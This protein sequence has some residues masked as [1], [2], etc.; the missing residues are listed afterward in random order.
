[1]K[2]ILSAL[3][4]VVILFNFILCNYVY[5]DKDDKYTDTSRYGGNA[6]MQEGDAERVVEEGKDKEGT[7]MNHEGFG[8]SIIG[9]LLQSAAALVNF[10]PFSIE[11]MLSIMTATPNSAG[12]TDFRNVAMSTTGD[13]E[14]H[15]TIERTVFN[16]ISI[17][18]AN[19]FNLK[20]TYT[21]GTGSQTKTINQHGILLKL[22]ETISGWFYT[23][24]LL[25]MM[26]NLIILIY[27][28][29]R[30]ATSSIASE[31]AKYKKMLINW[32]ESMLVL[33]FLHYLMYVIFYISDFML[34]IIVL[35]K[36][37]LK[38]TQNA[39]SFESTIIQTIYSDMM[40][41]GG[42][43]Y[44]LY[45]LFFWFV[46]A[47]H[48]KF[49]FMYFKRMLTLFFLVVISPFITVTYPIDK[50]GDGRA[51]AYENW[52]KEFVINVVIQPIH[53]ISY[54][55]FVYTA[56]KIAEK[57]PIVG[58]IFLLALGRVENIVRN[59]FKITDSVKNVNDA[60]KGGNRGGGIPFMNFI[61]RVKGK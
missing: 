19:V 7:S 10:F 21:V 24:R 15:Y 5:A 58:I 35:L 30:M 49:F 41:V 1:M 22:K 32:F 50:I 28:G 31:E 42:V 9:I 40:I 18:N 47:L 6:T 56:G 57:A 2:K 26:I 8:S 44:A 16:E 34:N 12:G 27:V 45:S 60:R 14:A 59:I 37:N 11:T 13:P 43:K 52:L 23:T 3:L 55:V 25:A 48:L 46:T 4:L 33:F 54:L 39:E 51:Q 61:G 53:A 36:E 38:N 17:L 20:N 29:I